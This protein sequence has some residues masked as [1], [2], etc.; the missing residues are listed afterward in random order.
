LLA[1]LRKKSAFFLNLI[2]SE[3]KY[4]KGPSEVS[5]GLAPSPPNR[6][7]VM[8]LESAME[9]VVRAGAHGRCRFAL[10]RF[11]TG[12]QPLGFR[13]PRLIQRPI[14]VVDN[15]LASMVLFEIHCATVYPLH[16]IQCDSHVM[17]E[18][19][20]VGPFHVIEMLL[21]LLSAHMRG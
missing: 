3:R 15:T 9:M 12:L 18:I 1:I 2:L 10:E 13:H 14:I 7:S 21:L 19:A 6:F 20:I 11:D 17:A 8:A 16:V 5:L 4:R